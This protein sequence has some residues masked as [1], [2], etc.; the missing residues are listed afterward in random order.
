[1]SITSTKLKANEKVHQIGQSIFAIDRKYTDLLA[2]GQ[3]SYG[4]VCSAID[5]STKR[6]VAI[7]K[8]SPMCK[9][10]EDSKHVLREI[11][12]MRYLGV[13]ENIVKLEDLHVR[14]SAD[15]I[16]IIMELFDTDLHRVISS[17]QPLTENH[18]K[19]FFFQLICGV[20]FLHQ[21]R[22]IHRDL[23]PGNLLVSRDCKLRITDFGLARERPIGRMHEDPD[24]S[25]DD[26]MTEHVVTRW[27]RACELMLLPDGLYTYAVD[28]WACGCILGEMLGRKPMFPGKNFVHQ[29]TLIFD[30]M[31]CPK[32]SETNHIRNG[33]ARKFLDAQVGKRKRPLT[34]LFP[35]A[36][37]ECLSLLDDL[38]VFDPMKR[39]SAEESL[40]SPFFDS[41][42]IGSKSL[43]FP[44]V[45]SGLEF[46]FERSTADKMQFRE[47]V[48]RE[49]MD[50]K[51]SRG[52]VKGPTIHSTGMPKHAPSAGASSGDP[53]AHDTNSVSSG[54][55]SGRLASAAQLLV[56][57]SSPS[58]KSATLRKDGDSSRLRSTGLDIRDHDEFGEEVITGAYQSHNSASPHKPLVLGNNIISSVHD[59]KVTST[60]A[61]SITARDLSHK[62]VSPQQ[63]PISSRG[64][65]AWADGDNKLECENVVTSTVFKV[66]TPTRKSSA[67]SLMSQGQGQ[68]TEES[69]KKLDDPLIVEQALNVLRSPSATAANS[70][71][72]DTLR[73]IGRSNS[74]SRPSHDRLPSSLLRD[75]LEDGTHYTAIPV[76]M[77]SGVRRSLDTD[78]DYR[79]EN[80]PSMQT[81][82]RPSMQTQARYIESAND[83]DEK[84]DDVSEADEIEATVVEKAIQP[85]K[86]PLTT[87][88]APNFSVMSWQRKQ[89]TTNLEPQQDENLNQKMTDDKARR[90]SG[91]ASLLRPTA[92]SSYRSGAQQ[93]P[94]MQPTYP[95]NNRSSSA[96]R[97]ASS[98]PRPAEPARAISGTHM[99]NGN[100][101]TANVRSRSTGRF[102]RDKL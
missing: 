21:N 99:P 13:H 22:I 63:R 81:Q 17:K 46:A 14:E 24:S 5:S 88:K 33:Q 16:Y 90:L 100:G 48:I 95:E 51:R 32:L 65:T 43:I 36:S 54:P 19:Y 30:V 57:S 98:G 35:S 27:Y 44:V 92:S 69:L 75:E 93:Q 2:I 76:A 82:A 11:R 4:V 29:L 10:I 71:S 9:H 78:Q 58:V 85:Q 77:S 73:I 68:V 59:T 25:I 41:V 31:G 8:I 12:L 15:E 91:L 64:R 18:L 87:A 52:L 84:D 26:P 6:K 50:F 67:S 28:M 45:D 42:G 83:D 97:R 70:P 1:M 66:L 79:I 40:L 102:Y 96:P 37:I 86:R 56:P 62:Q 80:R 74:I 60:K 72:R 94:T 7:K 34:A 101:A 53:R 39:C 49:V 55:S 61:P 20:R 3:G 47:F 89:Q 38:L 23:K